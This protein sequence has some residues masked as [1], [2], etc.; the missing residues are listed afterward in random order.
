MRLPRVIHRGGVIEDYEE[1]RSEGQALLT[2]LC[3]QLQSEDENSLL[4][5]SAEHYNDHYPSAGTD[6][7]WVLVSDEHV[8]QI[9]EATGTPKLFGHGHRFKLDWCARLDQIDRCA[10]G[11]QGAGIQSQ[12]CVA[13]HSSLLVCVYAGS[14]VLAVRLSQSYSLMARLASRLLS[15]LAATPSICNNCL[16][17]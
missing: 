14:I 15:H 10:A 2:T 12:M 5:S 9:T 13:E 1:L 11:L 4:P 3:R 6:R 17:R 8:L 7:T 16:R